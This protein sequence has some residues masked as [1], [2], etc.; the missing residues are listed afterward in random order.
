MMDSNIR[1]V[2]VSYMGQRILAFKLQGFGPGLT[3]FHPL[4]LHD[5]NKLGVDQLPAEATYKQNGVCGCL[6]N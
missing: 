4:F 5:G 2:K 6:R 3:Y 1:L